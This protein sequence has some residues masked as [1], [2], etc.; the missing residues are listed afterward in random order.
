MGWGP[1]L[2]ENERELATIIL[3]SLLPRLPLLCQDSLLLQ[4]MTH[5]N[6]SLSRLCVGEGVCRGA[7][8]LTCVEVNFLSGS[9]GTVTLVSILSRLETDSLFDLELTY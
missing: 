8:M 4:T 7:G 1:G 9:L 2:T 5:I 3:L 6:A